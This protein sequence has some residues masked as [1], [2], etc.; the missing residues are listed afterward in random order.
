MIYLLSC[1]YLIGN[2]LLFAWLIKS[3]TIVIRKGWVAISLC[4][5]IAGIP[6]W[7]IAFFSNLIK[8]KNK[9]R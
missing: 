7:L 1:L 4:F 6:L 2:G 9:K 8:T 3:R 5:L